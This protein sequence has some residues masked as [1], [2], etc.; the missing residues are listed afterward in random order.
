MLRERVTIGLD[1]G[2]SLESR[3][4]IRSFALVILGVDRSR[5]ICQERL[6]DLCFS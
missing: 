6:A 2:P 4:E 5:T 3:R 1:L